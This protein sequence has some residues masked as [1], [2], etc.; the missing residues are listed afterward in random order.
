MT[1]QGGSKGY[2][3]VFSCETG[4]GAFNVLHSFAGGASEG[5]Y[6]ESGLTLVG[7]TLYGMTKQGGSKD[8]GTIFS[9]GA[10]GNNFSLLHTF[11]NSGNN[12]TS[13][14]YGDLVSDG[15]T[16]YG[17]TC[18]GGSA[19]GVIFSYDTAG[20]GYRTLVCLDNYTGRTPYGGLTL[21][22]ATLYGMTSNRGAGYDGY[23]TVFSLMLSL[24]GDA[25]RDGTVNGTDLNT[26]LSNYNGSGK[27]W[28]H[29][30]FNN[31][32]TVNGTDLNAVLSNYNQSYSLGDGV[33]VPEPSTLLLFWAW[34]SSASLFALGGGVQAARDE[35]ERISDA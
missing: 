33:A 2:G 15:S 11:T 24:P 28:A 10:D 26:V 9:I 14:Y 20:A 5:R 12:G 18:G 7:S 27:D 8:Y 17:M 19:G 32:G 21:S 31:D 4:S 23:G 29:G 22:G 1:E 3:T 6:P 35:Q 34:A 13:P 16:L 25:N 30:D